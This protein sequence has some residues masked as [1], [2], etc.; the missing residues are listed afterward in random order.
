VTGLP[1]PTNYYGGKARLAPWIGGLLPSHR[2][3]L[4]PFAGQRGGAVR[5]GAQPDRDPE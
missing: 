1:P 2:T 4:E 3:Y 5:Q